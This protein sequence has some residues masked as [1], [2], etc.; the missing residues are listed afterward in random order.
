MISCI[1]DSLV[2]IESGFS[3]GDSIKRG[4][5]CF[6]G[7]RVVEICC[8]IR[9]DVFCVPLY[10]IFILSHCDIKIGLNVSVLSPI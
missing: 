8:K 2:S 3:L 1:M 9:H 7:V 4:F 10:T 5:S 6:W